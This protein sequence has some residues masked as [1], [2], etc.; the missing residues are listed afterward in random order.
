[1]QINAT[2][3]DGTIKI[4][5]P[6]QFKHRK[7]E[8]VVT[9]PEVE[10]EAMP[11]PSKT[12]AEPAQTN[13]ENSPGHTYLAKIKQILGADFQPRPAATVEQDKATLLEA[14]EERYS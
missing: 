6:F 5:S 1:M 13:Q 9:I 7:F 12:V 2:Y 14:L 3:E 4:P 10:I 11:Q 8:V